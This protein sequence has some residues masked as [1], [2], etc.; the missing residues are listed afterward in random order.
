MSKPWL[1]NAAVQI[2]PAAPSFADDADDCIMVP[3][4]TD[5][6]N[7]RLRRESRARWRAPLGSCRADLQAARLLMSMTGDSKK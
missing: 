6:P 3:I 5:R 4:L 1:S 2:G 7:T